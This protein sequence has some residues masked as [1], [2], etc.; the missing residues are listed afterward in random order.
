MIIFEGWQM[1]NHEITFNTSR[2]RR[3]LGPILSTRSPQRQFRLWIPAS[4]RAP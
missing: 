4:A 2:N 3:E 1:S